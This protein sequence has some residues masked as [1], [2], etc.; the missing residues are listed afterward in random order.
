MSSVFTLII[1]TYNR[2]DYLKRNL[3]FL[4]RN[5]FKY[6]ILVADSSSKEIQAINK[7][8][9]KKINL[10]VVY[11]EHH[12]EIKVRDKWIEALECANS[13]YVALC[14]DDDL[15]LPSSID[16][17]L[18]FLQENPDFSGCQGLSLN[19]LE[20]GSNI[21]INKIEY[22]LPG[23]THDDPLTRL[24][25]SLTHY[26][27]NVYGLY[28]RNVLK[29]ACVESSSI[30]SYLFLELFVCSALILS[31][32]VQ[33]L[34]I[35]SCLRNSSLVS[36][37]EHSE[38][39]P[40]IKNENEDFV[41]EYSFFHQELLSF[42]NKKIEERYTGNAALKIH[43][44]FLNYLSNYLKKLF[45]DDDALLQSY[46]ECK[47]ANLKQF[48]KYGSFKHRV[49]NSLVYRL[50]KWLRDEEQDILVSNTS[51]VDKRVQAIIGKNAF[52]DLIKEV[53]TFFG[54]L[55]QVKYKTFFD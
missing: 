35:I 3:Y 12:E 52:N 5:N 11:K 31:G 28:R 33:R 43:G 41:S 42:V 14:P 20:D 48:V 40:W 49:I 10:N 23:I 32:K 25:H 13:E 37:H 16:R 39:V 22:C 34:K 27:S 45:V 38:P 21:H 53:E 51:S 36:K 4:E 6:P 18:S 24:I 30:S 50:G 54:K 47:K 26:E 17:C 1:P 55:A 9:I 7:K 19:F 2:P 15:I 44:A 29:D 8:N 46:V